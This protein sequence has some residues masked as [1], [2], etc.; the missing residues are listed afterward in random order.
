MHLGRG[1][2]RAETPPG[3]FKTTRTGE[4]KDCPHVFARSPHIGI[5]TIDAIKILTCDA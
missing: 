3:M 2:H 4:A 5:E 1:L